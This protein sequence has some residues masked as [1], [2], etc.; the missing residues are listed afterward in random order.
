M[1]F[2]S[3]FFK[4][5]FFVENAHRTFGEKAEPG[6]RESEGSCRGSLLP[7]LGADLE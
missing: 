4:T 7:F 3:H 5:N 6:V 1:S 2:W